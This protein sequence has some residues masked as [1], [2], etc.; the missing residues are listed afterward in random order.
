MSLRFMRPPADSHAGRDMDPLAGIANLFDASIVLVV[1][2]MVALFMTYNLADLFDPA[3]K[4]TITKQG[5]DGRIEIVTKDGTEIKVQRVTDKELSGAGVRLG[6]AF[7][8][9][10]G[11]VVYVPE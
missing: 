11:R 9:E 7:Q 2:M 10:D 1:S 4:V 3:S 8:L 6:V 5:K